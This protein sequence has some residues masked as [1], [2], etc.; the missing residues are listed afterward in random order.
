MIK[1]KMARYI[2]SHGLTLTE[3]AAKAGV[4]RQALAQYGDDFSP[5]VKTLAKVAKAMTELGVP[6]T[7][8]ELVNIT[9]QYVE[10]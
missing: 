3:V 5:T 1:G 8:A 4:T 9:T 2:K 7:T 6:T 10:E